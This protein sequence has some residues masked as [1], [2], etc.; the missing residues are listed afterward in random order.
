[1]GMEFEG[2]ADP[3]HAVPSESVGFGGGEESSLSLV[4]GVKELF[5]FFEIVNHGVF[6]FEG[7][8]RIH[9]NDE[10]QLDFRSTTENASA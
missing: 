6:C 5:L 1:M 3:E 10:R 8:T 4:E 7:G 2:L 9:Y